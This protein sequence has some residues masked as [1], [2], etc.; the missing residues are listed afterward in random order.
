M[1]WKKLQN[2]FLQEKMSFTQNFPLGQGGKGEILPLS[3]FER[4]T[5]IISQ[6]VFLGLI[7]LSS[8]QLYTC[9]VSEMSVF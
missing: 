8:L 9:L 2:H 5:I 6:I 3:S 7:V 1:I 4:L